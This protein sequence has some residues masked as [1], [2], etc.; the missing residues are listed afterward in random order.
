MGAAAAVGTLMLLAGAFL[1]PARTVA[2]EP[3]SRVIAIIAERA[4]FGLDASLEVVS[5]LLA[6]SEDVGTATFGIAMTAEEMAELDLAGRMAFSNTMHAAIEGVV[7]GSPSFAGTFVDQTQDGSITVLVA[8]GDTGL[9]ARLDDLVPGDGSRTM[10]IRHVKYSLATLSRAM[11]DT[12]DRWAEI[13][14][15]VELVSVAVDTRANGLRVAV[16]EGDIAAAVMVQADLEA[17]VGVPVAFESAAPSL[18]EV[19]TSRDNCYTPMKA[20]SRIRHGG[21]NGSICG[22]GFHIRLGSGDEQLLTAGHC[23]YTGSLSWYH[24]GYGLVGSVQAS[25]YVYGGIDLQRIQMPD[26]QASDD[27]FGGPS[28][29]VGSRYPSQGEAVCASLSMTQTI[30]CGTIRD[31]YKSW[32][33]STCGCPVYGADHD[34]ISTQPGDSGSPIYVGTSSAVAVG[35]HNTGAGEFARVQDAFP[36]WGAVVT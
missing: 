35:I 36:A 31:A 2:A 6:G 15:E 14:P 34:S 17:R 9:A 3:D 7:D 29:I 23:G 19:C 33:S 21:V 13:T 20:G 28:N 10:H 24:Y 11:V 30:D 18:D 4:A 27:L 8:N 22:M 16:H 32:T 12:R 25:Y 5:S 1:P 26:P